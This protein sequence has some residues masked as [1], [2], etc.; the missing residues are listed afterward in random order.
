ME[1]R[2]KKLTFA[3]LQARVK[4]I[5]EHWLATN[6]SEAIVAAK[7]GK[8]MEKAV[9]D[10][11]VNALGI[12]DYYGRSIL[13]DE[14]TRKMITEEVDRKAKEALPVLLSTLSTIVEPALQEELQKIYSGEYQR[15]LREQV[16]FKAQAEAQ[17]FANSLFSTPF[18]KLAA[19]VAKA[20]I[21]EDPKEVPF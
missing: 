5:Q 17:A 11:A 10:T 1:G 13:Q 8:L 3:E 6:F 12:K 9:I 15:T 18:T 20:N 2:V 16:R 7:V 21:S 4:I 19:E 14:T